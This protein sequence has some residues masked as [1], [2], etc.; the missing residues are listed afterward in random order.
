[1]EGPCLVLRGVPRR[2]ESVPN[3]GL[4]A[5]RPSPFVLRPRGR[6]NATLELQPHDVATR[7]RGPRLH[8]PRL[9]E[10]VHE[11]HEAVAPR[12]RFHRIRLHRLR[13]VLARLVH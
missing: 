6:T 3:A 1:R 8:E 5:S 11:A 12:V 2:T 13:S 4:D 9:A 10:R 7:A